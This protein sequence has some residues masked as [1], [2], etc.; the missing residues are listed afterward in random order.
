MAY[1]A[2]D[3]EL[4]YDF[5]K[6]V[7]PDDPEMIEFQQFKQLFGEDGNIIVLG[8]KDSSIYTSLNFRRLKYL[9]DELGRIKGV[10]TV[11]SL[12]NMPRLVKD[13]Q[14]KK[15]SLAPVFTTIP[16]QQSR[17]DSLLNVAMD[18]K[19]FS[20]QLVN[21][22]NGALLMI[23]NIDRE[24]MNSPQRIRLI[25]DIQFAGQAFSE[26][27][28]IDIHY[29]GLPFIR[30]IMSE[31]VKKEMQMFL[32]LSV[33]VTGLIM[34][35]FFRSWDAV[36]FPLIIIGVIVIW[37]MGTLALFGYKITILS[38]LIPPI[39]VVIGIPNSIYLLNKFHQEIDKHGNKMKALS[40]VIRKVGLVTLITN[41]TTAIGFL[42]LAFTDITILKQFGLV[43]GINIL[44]TF[45]VS[46]ILIPAVFS[47][48]PTPQGKQLKH[49]QF[50][51]IDWTLNAL[52][53]LVHRHKYTVFFV[54]LALVIV[55]IVGV[56]Q[57]HSVSYMVDD[58]PEN[59][60]VKRDLEFFEDNFSGIMPLEILVD[61]GKPKGILRQ[62][63]LVK[64]NQ[65]E[66]FLDSLPHV[67]TPISVVSFVKA[68][69]Q[70][71]YNGNPAFYGLPNSQDRNFILRYFQGNTDQAGLMKNFIDSTAQKIRISLNIAD[72][73]SNKM[74][75]LIHGQIYPRIDQLF[76]QSDIQVRVT[77]TSPLFVKGNRF[78]I[79]NLRMSL[80]LAFFLI[81]LIMALLYGNL[82]MIIIS[83]IPNVIPLLIVGAIMGFLGIP[84]KPSTALIFSI[85]FGISVD[86][87]IHFLAKYRQELF[88][89]QF[90]VPLAVSKSIRET[91]S[92]MMYT[93]IV[94]FAGFIIFAGSGFGGTKALGLLTSTTLVFAMFTN[95]IV[96]PS[97]LLRFDDGKRKKDFYPLL[98]D[99]AFYQEDEDEEID[100]E[101]IEI[102]TKEAEN[103]KEFS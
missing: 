39:I 59:S 52:D 57:M 11:I 83:I 21:A 28:N 32:V 100:L 54:T 62:Q 89:N 56:F 45:L 101:L 64:I 10:N 68:A 31:K 30:T 7:P 53:L 17:L 5:S 77:G 29:A 93:S 34:L 43:A 41:F 38:G 69:R 14:R 4:S 76:S 87:S 88:A 90:F 1:H 16:D 51:A 103:Q 70:A 65:F 2:K 60:E 50:K 25:D 20:N 86:Y 80:L 96:L 78:L 55:T 8:I 6:V 12:P 46:I 36:L 33:L 85:A 84:L 102:Q 79:G 23:L 42:V 82:R 47:Y 94:L 15:F 22:Q 95:L 71:F 73:G 67:S 99:E 44:A 63:N 3:V 75:E 48:L 27:T 19:F 18:Q 26:H 98:D 66:S 35:F 81:S 91:G 58:L 61:T 13:S 74:D 72:L 97:L 9:N 40:R 92:S 37:S 24:V 49:L